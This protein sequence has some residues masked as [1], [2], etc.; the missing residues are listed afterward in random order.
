MPIVVPLP[1]RST[2]HYGRHTF[3]DDWVMGEYIA[4]LGY[5]DA[6]TGTSTTV[7]LTGFPANVIVHGALLEID[8]A[9]AG[10]ADATAALGDAGDID[11]LWTAFNLNAV[12]AGW[13]NVVQGAMTRFKFEA[14]YAPIITF[15]ATELDD[16]TAGAMTVH[17][18]YSVPNRH[19]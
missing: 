7:A 1:S 3:V 13:A 12:A 2:K 5:T 6:A 14:A 11:E 10:E 19:T 15:A 17:I 16:L 9:F 8:T 18:Y 4:T